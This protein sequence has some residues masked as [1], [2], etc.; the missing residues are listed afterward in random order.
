MPELNHQYGAPYARSNLSMNIPDSATLVALLLAQRDSFDS[1]YCA[2]IIIA[3]FSNAQVTL[4]T[5]GKGGGAIGAVLN[6]QPGVNLDSPNAM[7]QLGAAANAKLARTEIKL[8]CPNGKCCCNQ[9]Y[10]YGTFPVSI[11]A[12]I[13]VGMGKVIFGVLVGVTGT[14]DAT[15]SGDATIAGT[16]GSCK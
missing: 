16:I 8:S 7:Q 4:H 11:S 1:N 3:G 2:D 14:V 6:T 9:Q 13:S 12:H 15:I 5:G 10:Y